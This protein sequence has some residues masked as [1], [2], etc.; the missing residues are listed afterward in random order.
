LFH[1]LLHPF[2]LQ[3]SEDAHIKECRLTNLLILMLMQVSSEA[4]WNLNAM[5]KLG[6]GKPNH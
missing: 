4:K 5:L 6:E 1:V 3:P 2:S